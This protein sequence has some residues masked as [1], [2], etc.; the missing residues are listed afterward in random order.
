MYTKMS[1][2]MNSNYIH[3]HEKKKR[4]TELQSKENSQIEEGAA[5]DGQLKANFAESELPQIEKAKLSDRFNDEEQPEKIAVE[6]SEIRE[7][8]SE[9]NDDVDTPAAKAVKEPE[10]QEGLKSPVEKKPVEPKNKETPTS[11]N[12]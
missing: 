10:P 7:V 1:T 9:K 11:D 8:F 2:F 12:E 6:K 5:I 4:V 3:T